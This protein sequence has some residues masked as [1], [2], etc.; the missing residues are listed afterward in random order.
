MPTITLVTPS[1]AASSR[2][3][4]LGRATSI[5][6]DRKAKPPSPLPEGVIRQLV[7]EGHLRKRKEPRGTKERR[8]AER[9]SRKE[10]GATQTVEAQKQQQTEGTKKVLSP[11]PSPTKKQKK[12]ASAE[13]VAAKASS[14]S[15][16]RSTKD[17]ARGIKDDDA[18][19]DAEEAN[20]PPPSASASASR[21]PTRA[22]VHA[23]LSAMFAIGPDGEKPLLSRK[24]YKEMKERLMAEARERRAA[25]A[26][27]KKREAEENP[28]AAASAATKNAPS[29][30]AAPTDGQKYGKKSSRN[31][32][33]KLRPA[34]NGTDDEAAASP[35]PT[36]PNKPTAALP[37]KKV[38][39]PLPDDVDVIMS[40]RHKQRSAAATA[41][42]AERPRAEIPTSTV[43]PALLA[44]PA[45]EKKAS[46]AGGTSAEAMITPVRLPP[47][48]SS[49]L[50]LEVISPISPTTP[51][52]VEALSQ[53]ERH[54]A[55]LAA[56]EQQQQRD[57]AASPSSPHPQKASGG[58]GGGGAAVAS[59]AIDRA[60]ARASSI[61]Q[62]MDEQEVKKK[63][64]GPPPPPSP[65]ANNSS[66]TPSKKASE[67][68]K[69]VDGGE[70]QATRANHDAEEVKKQAVNETFPAAKRRQSDTTGA[71]A[72]STSTA[73]APSKETNPLKADHKAAGSAPTKVAPPPP[74]QVSTLAN[75][76]ATPSVAP[77]TS[78]PAQSRELTT[79]AV[80]TVQPAATTLT[81]EP[82][83]SVTPPP[84]EEAE[85]KPKKQLPTAAPKNAAT[86]VDST[87][88]AKEENAAPVAATTVPATKAVSQAKA[89][90][91]VL[92]PEVVP[93]TK[94]EL[95]PPPPE[96]PFIPKT[97]DEIR[98]AAAA[99]VAAYSARKAA[100]RAEQQAKAEAAERAM[101]AEA[102]AAYEAEMAAEAE[103]EAERARLARVEEEA[104]AMAT[105]AA[106]GEAPAEIV[107]AESTSSSAPAAAADKANT[108]DR[109]GMRD[110]IRQRL[111]QIKQQQQQEEE[112]SIGTL[113]LPHARKEPFAAVEESNAQPLLSS[114][115]G[116]SA[117]AA[118]LLMNTEGSPHTA[119][120]TI[121]AGFMLSAAADPNN[122]QRPSFQTPV[123]A[124]AQRLSSGGSATASTAPTSHHHYAAGRTLTAP[125]GG[126]ATQ[127]QQQQQQR[128]PPLHSRGR[129]GSHV[130]D[131]SRGSDLFRE[132]PEHDNSAVYYAAAGVGGD[133]TATAASAALM[134]GGTT[135]S[136][137][138]IGGG[139]G[140]G[141]G[142]YGGSGDEGEEASP[143]VGNVTAIVSFDD[144]DA[145]REV[146]MTS[147]MYEPPAAAAT[148]PTIVASSSAAMSRPTTPR[149]AHFAA[150]LA[151]VDAS[152]T[153]TS[154]AAD[155]ALTNPL[156]ALGAT[157]VQ[158]HN[159]GAPKSDTG[160]ANANAFCRS[161]CG[162]L[163]PNRALPAA[164]VAGG[165]SPAETSAAA[166]GGGAQ[167]PFARTPVSSPA[168]LRFDS[169]SAGNNADETTTYSPPPTYS[170]TSNRQQ[171]VDPAVALNFDDTIG[172]A[173]IAAALGTVNAVVSAVGSEEY[174]PA[175]TAS[176]EA[177]RGAIAAAATATTAG[178][179]GGA[180]SA[181]ATPH[182]RANDAGAV[183]PTVYVGG[184][185]TQAPLDLPLS[186][187]GGQQQ[188][189]PT[190]YDPHGSSGSTAIAFV[191]PPATT[192]LA[193]ASGG[194][195]TLQVASA[196]GARPSF[197]TSR[198]AN[199]S[200]GGQQ[201][202]QHP[203]HAHSAGALTAPEHHG[204]HFSAE[205][206]P[207]SLSEM[208]TANASTALYASSSAATTATTTN[209]FGASD[210]N[211]YAFG[212]SGGGSGAAAFERTP[213]RPAPLRYDSDEHPS[214]PSQQQ[215][216]QQQSATASSSGVASRPL[217][218]K[219][220]TARGPALSKPPAVVGTAVSGGKGSGHQEEVD[221]FVDFLERA[222]EATTSPTFSIPFV[223]PDGFISVSFEGSTGAG[224]SSSSYAKQ[225]TAAAGVAPSATSAS[226][227]AAAYSAPAPILSLPESFF[228]G[229]SDPQAAVDDNRSNNATSNAQSQPPPPATAKMDATSVD[230]PS[231]QSAASARHYTSP[232]PHHHRSRSRSR[233]V[234]SEGSVPP[235]RS[236]GHDDG[237]ESPDGLA[238]EGGAAVRPQ[239]PPIRH[240][241]E[242]SEA[243]TT[244]SGWGE[245]ISESDGG[246]AGAPQHASA[247]GISRAS[248][249]PVG[250]VTG[251]N[252]PELLLRAQQV[253]SGSESTVDMQQHDDD[254]GFAGPSSS[255]AGTTAARRGQQYHRYHLHSPGSKASRSRP[256]SNAS[257]RSASQ[258]SFTH[259]VTNATTV[260]APMGL[261]DAGGSADYTTSS[262]HGD[263]PY[264]APSSSHYAAPSLSH[265]FYG[266]PRYA[267]A[268]TALGGGAKVATASVA[269]GAG[270]AAL[271]LARPFDAE[272]DREERR[273]AARLELEVALA[274]AKLNAAEGA[275]RS[276]IRR[277]AD[278]EWRALRG[279][280]E[281]GEDRIIVRARMALRERA[282][283]AYAASRTYY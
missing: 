95:P 259:T 158:T 112:G 214:P 52:S 105:T 207:H 21:S 138:G 170:P 124:P 121:P 164:A 55:Q 22:E 68:K 166:M 261:R 205:T 156:V 282:S 227:V 251:S 31:A 245:C 100:E 96:I 91:T 24:A 274:R 254:G 128:S 109:S 146:V 283:T 66:T 111:E 51:L 199:P 208:P 135:A 54:Y 23:S 84:S 174:S 82:P 163:T 36:A 92:A 148:L 233:S 176:G 113:L 179:G 18:D 59:P 38:S 69:D 232:R 266:Q 193:L 108:V 206:P 210:S 234:G 189:R 172:A 171:S 99:A 157:V 139:R 268:T 49:M 131:L 130:S 167:Q 270:G 142:R 102:N 271:S 61:A 132:A 35:T 16:L 12:E 220:A 43:P 197:L 201:Q 150:T 136:P 242:G 237:Y 211:G 117:A 127:Q 119:H 5:P 97:I 256:A 281:D 125:S 183:A 267:T 181:E 247:A 147:P 58:G 101:I 278:A 4:S 32:S 228:A 40:P 25:V 28:K 104:E 258:Q 280:F 76:E 218:T 110:A 53:L 34:G 1:N 74:P 48:S 155:S 14:P 3:S 118:L 169:G 269:A 263:K 26:T 215:Q 120:S 145:A 241:R 238:A 29:A 129:S 73:A 239:H 122:G 223:R 152:A 141:S 188:P 62:W 272:R 33:P 20:H 56:E 57:A 255:A 13:V 191:G 190:F 83:A 246:G 175:D 165:F 116:S 6:D 64:S 144:D 222:S 90:P 262:V 182:R 226:T 260:A 154:R 72:P 221:A 279:E 9:Q 133:Y 70:V 185:P 10:L 15:P 77:S 88:A 276:D 71:S 243:S 159:E 93:K 7:A 94:E 67:S 151:A 257:S 143:G 2:R 225:I 37:N 50:H 19:S 86:V 275:G 253:R 126:A 81:A 46:V 230:P 192:S 236:R 216:Q 195:A 209:A 273:R 149:G 89:A 60:A 249:V 198:A 30:A 107:K 248:A 134:M 41:T 140:N 98:A 204:R 114:A 217:A 231:R 63:K 137:N 45:T 200:V 244:A 47:T 180:D 173:D 264:G 44:A 80:A 162:G 252:A 213:D 250:A 153:P 184:V 75:S 160:D 194:G 168:A 27:E 202:P 196:A 277:R 240:R 65:P 123:I 103:A 177:L 212:A 17:A 186:P 115:D 178:G 203:L 79:A 85:V 224:I 187:R 87:A 161:D 42:A 229:P 219:T 78:K 265:A 106:V 235:Q 39:P 8:V 11:S